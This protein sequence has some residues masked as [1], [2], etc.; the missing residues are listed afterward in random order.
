MQQLGMSDDELSAVDDRANRVMRDQIAELA[1]EIAAKSKTE[2]EHRKNELEVAVKF[3]GTG[4]LPE[5]RKA[6]ASMCEREPRR[7]KIPRQ[8]RPSR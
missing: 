1:S 7:R 4:S 3:S 5:S 8:P 2:D 6:T